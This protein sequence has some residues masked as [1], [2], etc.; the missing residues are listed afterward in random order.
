MNV[1]AINT[2]KICKWEVYTYDKAVHVEVNACK[3]LHM[4][5]DCIWGA[6]LVENSVGSGMHGGF[7]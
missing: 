7:M 5:K 4:C 6:M 1:S 3:W 2:G